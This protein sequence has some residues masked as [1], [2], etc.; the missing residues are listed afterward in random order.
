[1]EH[2]DISTEL[3]SF[4]H[5]EAGSRETFHV[6]DLGGMMSWRG[7]AHLGRAGL[8]DQSVTQID[9]VRYCHT[10]GVMD[11]VAKRILRVIRSSD[12]LYQNVIRNSAKSSEPFPV[13]WQIDEFNEANRNQ[14]IPAVDIRSI[15]AVIMTS[16]RT[17]EDGSTLNSIRGSWLQHFPR[18]VIYSDSA[19]P[20]Y[21]VEACCG[22]TDLGTN[23]NDAQKKL[24]HVYSR[25]W[26]KFAKVSNPPVWWFLFSED[27]ELQLKKD[28]SL[29]LL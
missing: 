5:V 13:Q 7:D 4:I 29:N 16:D 27:G 12:V 2:H 20:K 17:V 26:R 19:F 1:M 18:N 11:G 25:A 8:S 22:G 6:V 10:P 14:P 21:G 3:N 9:C 24:E 23:I 15:A 28:A